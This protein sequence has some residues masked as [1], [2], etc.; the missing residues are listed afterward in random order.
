[1]GHLEKN[2]LTLPIS[3]P[4]LKYEIAANNGLNCQQSCAENRLLRSIWRRERNW[5][6]TFSKHPVV[7][8]RSLADVVLQAH[9]VGQRLLRPHD[10]RGPVS[11]HP[12]NRAEQ[13][14]PRGVRASIEFRFVQIAS[15][16]ACV[17]CEL[18][19][20]PADDDDR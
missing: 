5:G 14:A 3:G 20:E 10:L 8:Q 18:E 19:G 13:S 15:A 1:M 9:H 7:A 16:S 11:G 17:P 4:E 2:K 12:E 6:Q